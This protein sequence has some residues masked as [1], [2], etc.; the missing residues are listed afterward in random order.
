MAIRGVSHVAVGVRDMDRSLDFY[1]DVIGLTVRFDET[2][3]FAGGSSGK[4]PSVKRRGVYLQFSDDPDASFVV[5]DQQLSRD[6]WGEPAELFQVGLHHFGFWVDDIDAIH[7]RAT[8]RGYEIITGPGD[9]DSIT[10]GEPPGKIIRSMFMRDPD[11]NTV[12][13]DQRKR[14][15]Q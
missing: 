8:G 7:E 2:E 12:Q 14:D 10:Y 5:L 9:A 3:E 4:F 1:R 6:P 15:D 13:C 11:G